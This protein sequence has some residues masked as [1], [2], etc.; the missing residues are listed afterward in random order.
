MV[1]IMPTLSR[2]PRSSSSLLRVLMTLSVIIFVTIGLVS[3]A[4]GGEHAFVVKYEPGPL[5]HDPDDPRWNALSSRTIALMG[6]LVVAPLHGEPSVTA[7]TI[8]GV[9]NGQAIAWRLDWADQTDDRI[10][11]LD[12]FPDGVAVQI[13]YDPSSLPSIT[14]GEPDKR[15]MMLHWT[16]DRQT[17]VDRG[18]VEL[19]HVY[20][21]WTWEWYPH[22]RPPYRYPHDWR[23]AAGLEYLGGSRRADRALANSPVREGFA[24]GY[25]SLTWKSKTAARGIGRYAHGH[26]TVVLLRPFEAPGTSN[27]QWGPGQ[28]A[29]LSVAVWDGGAHEV[30]G[31]KA[32]HYEWIPMMI[33]AV[34]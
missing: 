9:H 21:H 31:R 6:Q 27:P 25:S 29:A 18:Y 8:T 28:T 34:P 12:R 3:P 16:A 13:P 5:P 23:S 1:R 15:V 17:D 7:I 32:V 2:I 30:G 4:A 26:W 14:M 24:E 22:A 33:E 11:T 20:P 10:R 19:P